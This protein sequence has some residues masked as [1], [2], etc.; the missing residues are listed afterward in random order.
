MKKKKNR[1][2]SSREVSTGARGG[3]QLLSILVFLCVCCLLTGIYGVL[4][5]GTVPFS[6]RILKP[7]TETERPSAADGIG[8]AGNGG[9]G[10]RDDRLPGDDRGEYNRHAGWNGSY[11]HRSRPTDGAAAEGDHGGV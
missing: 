1:Y 10:N 6:F 2:R 5:S 3:K 8:A 9:Y 7:E 4:K 11:V